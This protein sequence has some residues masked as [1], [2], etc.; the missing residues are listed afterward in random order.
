MIIKAL[1][2]I[3]IETVFVHT[4]ISIKITHI[5]ED[6]LNSFIL[7]RILRIN[8]GDRYYSKYRVK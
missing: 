1:Y 2:S 4:I 6:Y 5:I 7:V 8:Y 3:I